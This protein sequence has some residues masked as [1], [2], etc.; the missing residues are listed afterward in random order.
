MEEFVWMKTEGMESGKWMRSFSQ[1]TLPTFQLSGFSKFVSCLHFLK[2]AP[3][4]FTATIYKKG[5]RV[6]DHSQGL[7]HTCT[8]SS[9][10]NDMNN[11]NH[12]MSQ[13]DESFISG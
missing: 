1:G 12:M 9:T 6:G 4:P 5:I 13:L 2:L 8:F 3:I 11:H 7:E 10:K